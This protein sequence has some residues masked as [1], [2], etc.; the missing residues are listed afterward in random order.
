MFVADALQ[1]VSE[2][3]TMKDRAATS[4][5]V[6]KRWGRST[7]EAANALLRAWRKRMLRRRRTWAGPCWYE[8]VLTAKGRNELAA[9]ETI[10][11]AGD[12][13]A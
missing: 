12:E 2:T 13:H 5:D 1:A 4:V 3:E 9:D 11:S 8:Y 6:A 7:D 10:I